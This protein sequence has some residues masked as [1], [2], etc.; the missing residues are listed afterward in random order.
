MALEEET[1][2]SRKRS[3]TEK[4]YTYQL[5]LKTSNLQTKKSELVKSIRGT[6]RKRGQS[7]N[8]VEFKKEFIEAQIMYSEFQDMVDE[9]KAFVKPGENVESIERMVDQVGREYGHI[10]SVTLGQRL[11]IW[12][13]LNNALM[14]LVLKRPK[15]PVGHPRKVT[16][17]R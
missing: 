9:I 14:I 12:N 4:G 6:L 16:S 7:T 15:G 8:L 11:N 13:L 10:L 17:Q 3:L 1:E 2:E 5:E